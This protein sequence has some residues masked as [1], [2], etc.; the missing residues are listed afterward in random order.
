MHGAPASRTRLSNPG[1]AHSPAFGNF[2]VFSALA[3]THPVSRAPLAAY[4]S[5]KSFP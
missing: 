2:R 3:E 5:H 4:G 1:E